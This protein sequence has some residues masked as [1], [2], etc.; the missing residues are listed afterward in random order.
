MAIIINFQEYANFK[1]KNDVARENISTENGQ[2]I[3]F[4]KEAI[5]Q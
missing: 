2:I 3:Y 5:K 4:H 1:K